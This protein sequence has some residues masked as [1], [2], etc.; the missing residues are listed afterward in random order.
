MET[1]LTLLVQAKMPLSFLWESF[2]ITSFLINRMPTPILNNISPF[3][4]LYGREPN[5]DFLRT[6][7]CSCFL[8]LRLYSKHKF[9]FHTQKCLMIGYSL[10]HKRYKCLDSTGKI[11]VARHVKFNESEFPYSYIFPSSNLN[12]DIQ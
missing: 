2:H 8:F 1:W 9:D 3:T 10:M 6:F 11:Y 12:Q 5:Y 7:G 4:K